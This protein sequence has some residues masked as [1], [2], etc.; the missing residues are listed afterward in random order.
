MSV[1]TWMRTLVAE[2]YRNARNV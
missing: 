1:A 2:S